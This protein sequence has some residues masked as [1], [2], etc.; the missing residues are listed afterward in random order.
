MSLARIAKKLELIRQV[1]HERATV[2]LILESGNLQFLK[3]APPGHF[4]SPIP[5]IEEVKATSGGG[6]NASLADILGLDVNI[7]VQHALARE[8]VTYYNEI[9]FPEQKQN[10][11]RYYFDNAYFS[12]GDGVVLY[13]M[14]RRFK[15]KRVIEVGSGFSSAEMLDINDKFFDG[16]IDFTFVEPFPDRLLGLLKEHDKDRCNILRARVQDV[17]QNLFAKLQEND[18][19][20]VDSSHVAKRRSDVLSLLFDT[21]PSLNRGV[22]LHFHDV[23]W[24]FEY[25]SS[26]LNEG[27]AWN[28]AY[29]LRAFLQYNSAF[30]ILYFNSMMEVHFSDFLSREMPLV[31]K[32]PSSVVT[33]GNTS[34]WIRKVH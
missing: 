14:M 5:N 6:D 22:I 32:K 3:F 33:P 8:F 18:I 34:L 12:Y 20:F 4:Y 31:M 29:L 16:N 2:E 26:W 13:S 7:E 15:P 30:Q 10:G 17:S 21:L 19:L 25:P 11:S 9:P 28:E 27:R 24:P 1:W 23:L